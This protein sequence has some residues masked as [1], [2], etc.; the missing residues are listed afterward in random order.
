MLKCSVDSSKRLRTYASKSGFDLTLDF[1]GLPQ[2]VDDYQF[3]L[4]IICSENEVVLDNQKKNIEPIELIPKKYE[5]LDVDRTIPVLKIEPDES[6]MTMRKYFEDVH[7]L[8]PTKDFK[9]HIS[10]SYNWEGEPPLKEIPMP[11]FKITGDV[12]TIKKFEDKRK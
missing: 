6:L 11:D 2:K 9:P 7:K 4:T 3:H 8:E 12:L 10:M 1:N 5:I